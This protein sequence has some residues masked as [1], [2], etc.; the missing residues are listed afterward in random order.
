MLSVIYLIFNEG[1]AARSG[2]AVT[3]SDLCQE[4]IRLARILVTLAPWEPEAAGLLSLMLL[5]D[6]R[7]IARSG[8]DGALITLEQQDR[9]QWNRDQIAEGIKFL[10]GALAR[11]VIGP[12]QIQ[13]AISAVHAS[14]ATYEDTD[15]AE[16]CV[17]YERLYAFEP[18]PVIRLNQAVAVSM[19]EGPEA[20]LE[21]LDALA[22]DGLLDGYQPY[23]A[24]CAD[25]H[26]RAGHKADACA[27]YRRAID[28]S[29]NAAERA[30]LESRLSGVT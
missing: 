16:I 17:W 19:I 2:Y 7:R 26:R 9:R 4:A 5:H 24:A 25:F 21:I 14:A 18:S 12:Y 10:D 15:W 13:A 22:A 23:H 27:A 8:R 3:R 11:E 20:G 1:Y 28:L 29:D 30:F 6:S